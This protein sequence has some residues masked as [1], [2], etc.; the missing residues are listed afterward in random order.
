M[1]TEYSKQV[2]SAY[3]PE[4]TASQVKFLA[5]SWAGYLSMFFFV[6]VEL[7]KCRA[8]VKTDGKMAYS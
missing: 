1:A 5:G 6:P 8:Q 2:I 4:L 7:L 3:C